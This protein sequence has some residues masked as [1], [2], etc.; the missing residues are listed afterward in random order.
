MRRSFQLACVSFAVVLALVGSA[1][2]ECVGDCDGN[3]DV[4]INELIT[5]INIALGTAPLSGCPAFDQNGD[6]QVVVSELIL[7][8]NNALS[9]CPPPGGECGDGKVDP[10]E[11]CDRGDTWGGDGCA[12]NCTNEHK[13]PCSFSAGSGAT[14]QTTLFAVPIPIEGSQTLTIGKA[15][16][17]SGEIPAVIKA[18]EMIFE[19][20]SV[21]GLVCACVRGAAMPQF[22]PGNTASGS[23]GCGEEGLAEVDY[24][25]PIDHNVTPGSPGNGGGL[26]DDPGCEHGDLEDGS[27]DMPHA[28]V[29]NSKRQLQFTGGGPRGSVFLRAVN[30]ISLLQDGGACAYDCG[31]E[32]IGEDCLPCTADDPNQAEP[33]DLPL[34]TG[35]AEGA[36]FDANNSPGK[37]IAKGSGTPCSSASQCPTGETC[38][39][40]PDGKVC[41][42]QSNCTCEVRCGS[43]LCATVVTGN[44]V[45]CDLIESDPEHAMSG[46][47]LV[48]ALSSV[49]TATIADNIVTAFFGCQ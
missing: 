3:G 39:S 44:V 40:V 4:V 21:P 29:C 24:F 13:L 1:R 33:G 16:D 7:A 42:T 35:T 25:A 28:G 41:T 32:N 38:W 10:G 49:D 12:A 47:K 8:I 2:A 19:P 9:G 43:Q 6:G 26:P 18:D 34:T 20:V 14:L 27:P 23:V 11:E 46:A 31:V 45:N 30:A 22:G 5:G 15:T 17:E 48:G 37:K 36:V